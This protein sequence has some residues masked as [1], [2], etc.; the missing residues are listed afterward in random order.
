MNLCRYLDQLQ[1]NV[2]PHHRTPRISL[3]G[4][5]DA[6]QRVFLDQ[7]SPVAPAL[8]DPPVQGPPHRVLR[9]APNSAPYRPVGCMRGL[10]AT[11]EDLTAYSDDSGSSMDSRRS[12]RQRNTRWYSDLKVRPS[13]L[14][15]ITV[16]VEGPPAP[17]T[18]TSHLDAYL[19]RLRSS[20]Y[21]RAARAP[22]VHLGPAVA[23]RESFSLSSQSLLGRRP[24]RWRFP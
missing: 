13:K 19:C 16:H 3:P 2:V 10:G 1:V 21:L 7:P 24:R 14:A 9:G 11:R 6:V 5:L 15:P 17:A 12:T 22:A 4:E 23:L 20:L 8:A 18:N